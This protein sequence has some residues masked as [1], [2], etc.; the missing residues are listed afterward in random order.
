MY[1]PTVYV[2]LTINFISFIAFGL[3]KLKAVNGWWRIPEKVL[4][5]WA[6][7]GGSVGAFLAMLLFRHKIR[8]P[9]FR[10]GIPVIMIAEASLLF[11]FVY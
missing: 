11:Y 1:L 6:I 7:A 9:L 4:L 5:G 10:F 2:L 3:D 8:K